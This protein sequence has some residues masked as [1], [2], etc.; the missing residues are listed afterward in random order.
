MNCKVGDRVKYDTEGNWN[1][2]DVSVE[3]TIIYID[4]DPEDP[5]C[6]AILVDPKLHN[7]EGQKFLEA[8]AYTLE[9]LKDSSYISQAVFRKHF[10]SVVGDC[11]VVWGREDNTTKTSTE[12]ELDQLINKLEKEII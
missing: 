5:N 3:G 1:N 11:V 8:G 2:N 12:Y 4:R 7:E 6:Y 10:K 9:D